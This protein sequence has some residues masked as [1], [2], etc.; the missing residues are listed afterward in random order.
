MKYVLP[1]FAS[2][3]GSFGIVTCAAGGNALAGLGGYLN[4]ILASL[5]SDCV[6]TQILQSVP[7]L[8]NTGNGGLNIESVAIEFATALVGSV[9]LA[10][11]PGV[12]SRLRTHHARRRV[13]VSPR[14]DIGGLR[15]RSAT[16]G[17]L[18]PRAGGNRG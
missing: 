15:V 12:V 4:E 7:V 2:E 16:V 8:A 3:L 5:V 14:C 13:S 18:K 17:T 9:L 11:T 1:K 6:G 10:I